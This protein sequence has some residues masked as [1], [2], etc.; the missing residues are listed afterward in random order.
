MRTT[1]ACDARNTFDF[2]RAVKAANG[3]R[4]LLCKA[5]CRCQEDREN[6]QPSACSCSNLWH[7]HCAVLLIEEAM[8]S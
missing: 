4:L 1:L 5:G 3:R 7:T 8:W 6:A 2:R